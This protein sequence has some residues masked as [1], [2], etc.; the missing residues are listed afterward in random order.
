MSTAEDLVYPLDH[1]TAE[2]V[3]TGSRALDG[4]AAI[5]FVP[6]AQQPGPAAVWHD[7][8]WS[9]VDPS[10]TTRIA[11]LAVAGSAMTGA[12]VYPGIGAFACFLRY[13]AADGSVRTRAAGTLAFR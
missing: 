10:A 1:F 5:A 8:T 4:Q 9:D 12:G 7:A 3:V 11:G 2:W 13:T 6:P